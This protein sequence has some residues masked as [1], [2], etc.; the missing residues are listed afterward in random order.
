[1]QIL[2]LTETK[3]RRSERNTTKPDLSTTLFHEEMNLEMIDRKMWKHLAQT[4]I[5]NTLIISSI[6]ILMRNTDS[7]TISNN[8]TNSSVLNITV[9]SNSNT[10]MRAISSG[11]RTLLEMLRM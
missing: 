1:M 9:N 11:Q 5:A 8:T 4:P 10:T 3:A 6:I 2:R 7:S